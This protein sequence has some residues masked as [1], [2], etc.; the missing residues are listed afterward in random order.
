VADVGLYGIEFVAMGR[1]GT[2]IIDD[3]VPCARGATGLW[4]P[5]FASPR[6]D[7][8]SG[9]KVL[10]PMLFEKAFAKLHRSYECT[11]LGSYECAQLG[12]RGQGGASCGPPARRRMGDARRGA[13]RYRSRW[14]RAGL[15][16]R[17]SSRAVPR[18]STAGGRLAGD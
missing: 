18:H 4:E 1:W 15:C 17:P 5:L 9:T 13:R 10:W 14:R 7:G 16:G 8:S 2:V 6:S 12:W 3:C 11:Q